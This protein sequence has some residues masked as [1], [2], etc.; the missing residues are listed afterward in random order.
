MP[1]ISPVWE[2]LRAAEDLQESGGEEA[3]T[4]PP[5]RRRRNNEAV[6]D[7]D[8]DEENIA[9]ASDD[10]NGE[11]EDGEPEPEPAIP[12]K[13]DGHFFVQNSRVFDPCARR[14]SG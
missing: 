3:R 11:E 10:D 2:E 6:G 5:K 7:E 4:P 13:L 12:P 9:G 1:V 14:H 8:E